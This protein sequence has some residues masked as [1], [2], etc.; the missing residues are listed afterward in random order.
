MTQ[1]IREQQTHRDL[2][3]VT[4]SVDFHRNRASFIKRW[5]GYLLPHKRCSFSMIKVAFG[6]T[7]RIKLRMD[8]L[9][10]KEWLRP[11]RGG[12][13]RVPTPTGTSSGAKPFSEY[14]LL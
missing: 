10:R 6:A 9:L 4:P 1:E 11:R 7:I 12:D 5:D 2:A 3:L 14:A 13:P 8:V